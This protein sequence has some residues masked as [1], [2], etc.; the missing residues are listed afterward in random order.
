MGGPMALTN[1]SVFIFH[2]GKVYP[3]LER[4]SRKRP[5]SAIARVILKLANHVQFGRT[6]RSKEYMEDLAQ[7]LFPEFRAGA[8]LTVK[9]DCVLPQTDWQGISQVVL[10]WPDANG[11]GWGAIERDVLRRAPAGVRM[12]AVSGRRR[13][14]ALTPRLLATQRWKRFLEKSLAV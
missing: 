8:M 11:M 6:V 4:W 9:E 12:I 7:E 1:T 10:L 2:D 14:F 13:I 3:S 5:D